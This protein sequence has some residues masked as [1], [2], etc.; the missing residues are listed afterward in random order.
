MSDSWALGNLCALLVDAGRLRGRA[1]PALGISISKEEGVC[2]SVAV[3]ALQRVLVSFLDWYS[4]GIVLELWLTL[5]MAAWL[6]GKHRDVSKL[7]RTPN[8]GEAVARFF[9]ELEGPA[10]C[11]MSVFC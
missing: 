2:L 5:E 1:L 4:R 7:F 6:G 10:E 9:V 8:T 3:E 11:S